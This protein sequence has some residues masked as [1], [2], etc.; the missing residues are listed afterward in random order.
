MQSP[1]IDISYS[2]DGVAQITLNRPEKRNALNK[3]MILFMQTV[4][5]KWSTDKQIRI[6]VLNAK[7]SC[8]CAG[9][10]LAWM[11][12][13]IQH[14]DEENLYDIQVFA[15]LLST[16]YT[17]PKPVV[18]VVQGEAYG[19]AMGL[20]A[21]SDIAIAQYDSQFCLSEVK[22]GLIP[23]IISPYLVNTIG[24]R[25]TQRYAISAETFSAD[26]AKNIGLIHETTEK[27]T[28]QPCLQKIIKSL[29][30]CS[31]DAQH[32]T[33]SLLQHV[34]KTASITP[35]LIQDTIELITK[36]RISPEAQEGSKAFLNKRTPSWVK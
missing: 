3:E 34:Q 6:V 28:L 24:I 21:A 13:S 15:D 23:A 12:E 33:K 25:H 1:F 35:A 36:T 8:F 17:F 32:K 11:T 29:Q 2:D 26:I 31:P 5:N 27:E 16:L 18:T 20:I 22:I 4:L 30:L 7:G 10:D 19:G 14:T 9:A